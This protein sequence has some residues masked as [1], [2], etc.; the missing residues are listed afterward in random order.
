MHAASAQATSFVLSGQLLICR[1]MPC[2]AAGTPMTEPG[3]NS[4]DHKLLPAHAGSN[5]SKTVAAHTDAGNPAV[6]LP[7]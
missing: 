3:L 1:G 7:H 5:I 4:P 6:A 2:S